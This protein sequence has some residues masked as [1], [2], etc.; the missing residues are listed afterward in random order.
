MVFVSL[1]SIRADLRLPGRFGRLV[2]RIFWAFERIMENKPRVRR[3]NAVANI[4]RTLNE[5]YDDLMQMDAPGGIQ[6]EVIEQ[7]TDKTSPAG[8]AGI[9]VSVGTQWVLLGLTVLG[10]R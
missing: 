8:L 9:V 4:D 5:L 7:T 2:A 10:G 6:A 3:K 1:Y